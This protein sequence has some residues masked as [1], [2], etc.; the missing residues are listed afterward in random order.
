MAP[1]AALNSFVLTLA[2]T[3]LAWAALSAVTRDGPRAALAA[4]L[5]VT[6]FLSQF[7]IQIVLE[8]S[9]LAGR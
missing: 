7:E 6:A 4:S 1:S 8:L 2:V 9:A 3:L 5:L